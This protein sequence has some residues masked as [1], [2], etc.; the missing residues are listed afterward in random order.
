MQADLLAEL[1]DAARQ[2]RLGR[3][4]PM[5][6]GISDEAWFAIQADFRRLLELEGV[7]MEK[8]AAAMGEGFSPATLRSF[9]DADARPSASKGE[10]DRVPRALNAFF[11]LIAQRAEAK[12]PAGF[13]RTRVAERALTVIEQASIHGFVALITGPPGIGKSMAIEAARSLIPGLVVFRVRQSS[14]RPTALLRQVAS[15]LGLKGASSH[16]DIAERRV[17]DALAGTGRTLVIDEAH[18]LHSAGLEV[19]RDIHDEAGV[20]MVL[21]G[22]RDLM[23][24][25]DGEELYGQLSSRIGL[26]YDATPD[27]VAGGPDGGG[28]P[29]YSPEEVARVFAGGKVRLTTDGLSTLAR[30]A[31]LPGLG[32][33]RL[34]RQVVTLAAW[35]TWPVPRRCGPCR[36]PSLSPSVRRSSTPAR[37]RSSRSS[38]CRNWDCPGRP[39]IASSISSRSSFG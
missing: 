13:V 22:T 18:R 37:G 10:G 38:D 26:R 24:T 34:A 21:V 1:R 2:L 9:R 31:N 15:T 33:L 30:I 6:G 36:V 35:A 19:L 27:A 16:A 3:Q 17:I 29:L 28:R 5:S 25:I 32:G 14:R 12:L 20:P 11:E 8:V 7:H 4:L 39:L 23:A